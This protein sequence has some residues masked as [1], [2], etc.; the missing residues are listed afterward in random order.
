MKQAVGG[1]DEVPEKIVKAFRDREKAI[2]GQRLALLEI[3][4]FLQDISSSRSIFICID[5]LDKCSQGL[6][7]KLNSLNQILHKSPGAW[8]FLTG[9]LHIWGEVKK[10]LSGRATTRSITDTEI[11][12]IKF[13]RVNLKEDTMLDTI[14]E[15]LWEG[16][17]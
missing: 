11:D 12:T 7:V 14:G 6:R 1:L 2:V 10:H 13:L 3:V 8:I 4:G 17:I 15:S 5:A 9:R 16:M